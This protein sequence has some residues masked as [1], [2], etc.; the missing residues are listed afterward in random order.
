[1]HHLL[2]MAVGI[3]RVE[4]ELVEELAVEPP[5]QELTLVERAVLKQAVPLLVWPLAWAIHRTIKDWV[6]LP[7]LP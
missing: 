7:L 2:Q 1:M 5:V 4:P 6:H 3:G